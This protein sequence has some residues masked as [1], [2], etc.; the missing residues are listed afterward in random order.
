MIEMVR[1]EIMDSGKATTWDDIAGLEFAKETI[2]VIFKK[3]FN[4]IS[5]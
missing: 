5:P 1:N 3:I 4:R 2:K